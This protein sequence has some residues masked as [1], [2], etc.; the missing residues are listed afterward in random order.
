MHTYTYVHVAQ[1][2]RNIRNKH[3]FRNSVFDIIQLKYM[4]KIFKIRKES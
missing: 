1:I 2:L 4:I 3:L